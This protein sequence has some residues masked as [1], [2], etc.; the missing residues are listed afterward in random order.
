MSYI[1]LYRQ[2]A[3]VGCA[4]VALWLS[5]VVAGDA[6]P[7]SC[8]VDGCEIKILRVAPENGELRVTFDANFTP[9]VSKNHIHVWWGEQYD[10]KQ[11]GRNAKSEFGVVQGKW[12]RH[13]DYPEYLT[14][15]AASL[16]VRGTATTLCTTA[17]DRNHNVLDP[18]LHHCLDI[19]EHL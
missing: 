19:S 11:V 7:N 8:P 17:A 1:S 14:T 15:G 18:V 12:H 2:L 16:R 6:M 4:L 3:K 9:D 13:D 10:V 5:G